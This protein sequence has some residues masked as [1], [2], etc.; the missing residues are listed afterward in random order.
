M[1]WFRTT[2]PETGEA[3]EVAAVYFPRHRGAGDA[4]GAPLEPDDAESV[5]VCEVRGRG[6]E[7]RDFSA[8]QEA[9]ERQAWRCATEPDL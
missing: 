3:L 2:H 1:F 8:F 6:G 5:C 4:S 7:I 9:L